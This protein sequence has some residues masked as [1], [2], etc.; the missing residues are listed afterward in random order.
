MA[1]TAD[2][3]L[4]YQYMQVRERERHVEITVRKGR[5]TLCVCVFSRAGWAREGE[6]GGMRRKWRER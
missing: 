5:E 2:G 1:K 3:G 6:R 4:K